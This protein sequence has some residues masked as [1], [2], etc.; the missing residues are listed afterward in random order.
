MGPFLS[1]SVFAEDEPRI[2]EKFFTGSGAGDKGLSGTLQQEL[3]NTRI[4]LFK[5]VIPLY[6]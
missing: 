5:V 3:E 4:L 6:S 2:A 1:V